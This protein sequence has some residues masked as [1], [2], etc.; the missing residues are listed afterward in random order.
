MVV[1][2]RIEAPGNQGFSVRVGYRR[3][4]IDSTSGLVL[5]A[6]QPEEVR[7]EWRTKLAPTVSQKVWKRLR[8]ASRAGSH[9]EVCEGG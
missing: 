6:F 1:V 5:F 2:A 7:A 4:L 3:P 9:A 8:R